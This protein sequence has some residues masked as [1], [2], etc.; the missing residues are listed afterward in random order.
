MKRKNFL[1]IIFTI[2]LFFSA[3]STAQETEPNIGVIS[4][5]ESFN[6]AADYKDDK[7]IFR[8]LQFRAPYSQIYQ[9][10]FINK[11]GSASSVTVT[12]FSK[13]NGRFTKLT[14]SQTGEI[15]KKLSDF[16]SRE[17][18]QNSPVIDEQLYSVFVFNDGQKSVRY[19]FSGQIPYEI[20]QII[21]LLDGEFNK[22]EKIRY[23]EFLEQ[24]KLLKE[25]YG[26]WLNKA[27]IVRPG[28]SGSYSLKNENTTTLWLK[29][30]RQPVSEDKK[31]QIPVYYALIF[32]PEGRTIGGAGG[33]NRSDDPLSTN[34]ISWAISAGYEREKEFVIEYN[35]VNFSVKI[36]NS[37]YQLRKGNLFIIRIGKDWKPQI[38]QL[39]TYLDKPADEKSVIALFN[40]E[41]SGELLELRQD[42]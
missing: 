30:F 40:K 41:L 34:G 20:R 33:G 8:F 31:I 17:N 32:Y 9:Q 12:P 6:R 5:I 16:V 18:N 21:D 24:G 14:E 13:R 3:S 1:L 11:D 25:K 10:T 15:R 4:S 36:E 27:G 22:S 35:A 38:S 7:I 28:S 2:S 37:N 19:N 42:F 23:E 39:K 29:G 26:D